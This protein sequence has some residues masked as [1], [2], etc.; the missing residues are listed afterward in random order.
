MQ[1]SLKITEERHSIGEPV[2]HLIAQLELL[3][4]ATVTVKFSP[5]WFGDVAPQS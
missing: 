2:V 5:N 4:S 1:S 3:D